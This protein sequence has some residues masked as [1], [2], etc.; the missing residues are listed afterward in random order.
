MSEGVASRSSPTWGWSLGQSWLTI[1]IPNLTYHVK[2]DEVRFIE[3]RKETK[4]EKATV[5]IYLKGQDQITIEG[6]FSEELGEILF[7]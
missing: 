3:T 7:R 6:I 5:K 1:T 2:L 4:T